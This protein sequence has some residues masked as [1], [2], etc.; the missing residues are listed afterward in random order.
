MC[1]AIENEPFWYENII[2]RCKIT[3]FYAYV[4]VK[5]V[6]ICV[7]FAIALAYVIKM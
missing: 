3:T 2:S 5:I 6:T 7:I 1:F 4:C